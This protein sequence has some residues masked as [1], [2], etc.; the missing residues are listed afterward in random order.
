M[1][2]RVFVRATWRM[3]RLRSRSHELTFRD[4]AAGRDLNCICRCTC[5]SLTASAAQEHHGRETAGLNLSLRQ[6]CP[7]R[8]Y[9]RQR[10]RTPL[11]PP[12][13]SCGRGLRI[14]GE[15]TAEPADLPPPLRARLLIA[16]RNF[17]TGR[18][19]ARR[20]APGRFAVAS[21]SRPAA[22]GAGVAV[23]GRRWPAFPPSRWVP[24][25]PRAQD[26]RALRGLPALGRLVSAF[27][28]AS[29]RHALLREFFERRPRLQAAPAVP[30]R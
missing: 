25:Q 23:W 13:G 16:D 26:S 8:V 29:V 14:N 21:E 28:S 27:I 30:R 11:S 1:T 20:R 9:S 24:A 10:R 2:V 3:S 17:Y 4:P 12:A 5:R 7:A 15:P 19:G 18:T 22:T 6:F